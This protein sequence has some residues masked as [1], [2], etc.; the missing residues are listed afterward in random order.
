MSRSELISRPDGRR[1][2]WGL[3][4]L[5]LCRLKQMESCSREFE[6]RLPK[7]LLSNHSPP[8]HPSCTAKPGFELLRLRRFMACLTRNGCAMMLLMPGGWFSVAL[9]WVSGTLL[10]RALLLAA[11]CMVPVLISLH[12]FQ[13]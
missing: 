4:L 13:P 12:P 5:G 8:P 2:T 10:N 1:R 11:P 3:G 7:A 6:A 9:A